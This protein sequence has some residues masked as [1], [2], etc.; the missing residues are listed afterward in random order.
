MERL[1]RRKRLFCPSWKAAS[2][3]E[4]IQYAARHGPVRTE[5]A[6]LYSLAKRKRIVTGKKLSRYDVAE[7][8][9]LASTM[10]GSARH[11]AREI[12]KNPYWSDLCLCTIDQILKNQSWV[13][14]NYSC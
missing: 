2:C 13:D 12:V 7:L 11:R 9:I 1:V 4:D 5:G 10:S 14:L 8:R 3:V 6:P